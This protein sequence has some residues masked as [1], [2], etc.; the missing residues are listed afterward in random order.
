MNTPGFAEGLLHMDR[1][2]GAQ[3][4]AFARFLFIKDREIEG[5]SATGKECVG[6]DDIVDESVLVGFVDT[7]QEN[8]DGS[9]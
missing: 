2:L 5:K 4:Q 8:W 7:Q 9:R 6:I 3:L 1:R